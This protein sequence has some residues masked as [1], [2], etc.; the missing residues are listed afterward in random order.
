MFTYLFCILYPHDLFYI[1]KHISL[2]PPFTHFTHPLGVI[3][4]STDISIIRNFGK[5][6]NSSHFCP[7][8]NCSDTLRLLHMLSFTLHENSTQSESKGIWRTIS[9][10]CHPGKQQP[11]SIYSVMLQADAKH[12]HTHTESVSG[13]SYQGNQDFHYCWRVT[14]LRGGKI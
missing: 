5:I 10:T 12:T 14:E 9:A 4:M 1:W 7:W 11:D 6:T 2:Y 3:I 8:Q 13:L